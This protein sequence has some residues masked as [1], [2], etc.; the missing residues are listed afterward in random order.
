M[1]STERLLLY[2][3]PRWAGVT[4]LTL[5]EPLSDLWI[6]GMQASHHLD[7]PYEPDGCEQLRAELLQD[8]L[9]APAA[10]AFHANGRIRTIR[11]LEEAMAN[12]R[13]SPVP[14]PSG[15]LARLLPRDELAMLKLSQPQTA[16]IS[17]R[18]KTTGGTRTRYSKTTQPSRRGR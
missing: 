11:D 14:S 10:D 6:S 3:L 15:Q 8:F 4:V 5:S 18:R 2:T 16:T 13:Q 9:E 7:L 12:I 1:N 17:H